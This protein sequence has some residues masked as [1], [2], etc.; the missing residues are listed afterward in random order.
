MIKES[1]PPECAV[2]RQL[3]RIDIHIRRRWW[4][5]YIDNP[6]WTFTRAIQATEGLADNQRSFDYATILY[7]WD[8]T[9]ASEPALENAPGRQENN[10][11]DGGDYSESAPWHQEDNAKDYSLENTTANSGDW[12]YCAEN[13]AEESGD[14]HYSE[15]DYNPT[16]IAEAGSGSRVRAARNRY[17]LEHEGAAEANIQR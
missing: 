11:E 8:L 14:W 7:Q 5:N 10:A 12:D 13:I 2:I 4:K 1:P 16:N 6:T 3:A 17:W 15:W 9:C